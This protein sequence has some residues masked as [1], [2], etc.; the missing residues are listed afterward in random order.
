MKIYFIRHG[1]TA[2]NREGRYVGRTDEPLLEESFAAIRKWSAPAV[3]QVV[4]SPMLRCRQTAEALYPGVPL[5]VQEG[6]QEMDFGEFEYKNYEE[7]NGNTD[8]Q[9]Y[10]DSGGTTDFPGGESVVRFKVRCKNAFLKAMDVVEAENRQAVAF[11]VHGGTIMS[12]LESYGIPAR[13][14]FEWQVKNGACIAGEWMKDIKKIQILDSTWTGAIA[15][16]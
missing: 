12:I 14:Y 3:E 7:L 2:G 9:A 4:T 16:E 5:R 6:L 10:I 1:Q 13:N 15:R 11:V 8:Y